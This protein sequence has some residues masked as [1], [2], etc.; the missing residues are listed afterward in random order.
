MTALLLPSVEA[1]NPSR[2]AN[3]NLETL[4]FPAKMPSL[5]QGKKA[6]VDEEVFEV[7]GME[8]GKET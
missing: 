2:L 4:G 7:K 5:P 8:K 6:M 1:V 3:Q